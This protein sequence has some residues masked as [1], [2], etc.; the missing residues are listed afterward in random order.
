MLSLESV[1]VESVQTPQ[2]SDSSGV[3]FVREQ[4]MPLSLRVEDAHF[5]FGE[6]L[7][8]GDEDGACNAVNTLCGFCFDERTFYV[9]VSR[10]SA[11]VDAL[12]RNRDLLPGQATA[13]KLMLGKLR[14]E[15]L[16]EIPSTA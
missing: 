11:L 13:M 16:Q 15:H 7:V 12:E 9:H 5:R 4:G 2:V 6:F 1:V 3:H 14:F 8:E 10:M